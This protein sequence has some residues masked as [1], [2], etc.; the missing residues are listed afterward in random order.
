MTTEAAPKLW[1]IRELLSWSRGWFEQK[2]VD[3][4]RLTAEL[5][6]SHVLKVPRI[7]LYADFDRPLERSELARYKELVTRRARGEPT[8]YLVGVQEFYGRPFK[9]DPRALIP[10]PE[11]ELL[12]G[13]V[14]RDFA[15]D[16]APRFAD[17]GCGCGTL[18]LTMAAERPNANVVLTDVSPDAAALAQENALL[19]NLAPRVEVRLGPL[20][21]PLGADVFDA[22][23]ANLPYVPEGER[24]TLPVH[25]R[26]HE[27]H[28]ALFG[29]P[30]GLDLIRALVPAVARNVRLGGLL[31]LEHGAEHG[32]LVPALFEPDLWETPVV[33]RDLAGLDR[34]T[35]AVRR[36]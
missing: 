21:A 34:F 36:R 5:L 13:R 20:A 11:T 2:Q 19:L 26:E 17:V 30:D 35:W 16:A 28:L 25:I 23:V 22:V 9:V 15:R 31:A 14:L 27:P 4:A 6:L 7:K 1:T 12:A 8:Q 33:E 3:S 29:G 24:A 18:G 32:E 10:R